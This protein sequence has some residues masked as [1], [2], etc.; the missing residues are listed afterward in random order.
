MSLAAHGL[1]HF[2]VLEATASAACSEVKVKWPFFKLADMLGEFPRRPDGIVAD[3]LA[4]AD[5]NVIQ[6]RSGFD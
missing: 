3:E 5:G 6:I 2:H 1:I 4:G